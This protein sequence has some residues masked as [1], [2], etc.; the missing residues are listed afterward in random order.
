MSNIFTMNRRQFLKTGATFLGAGLLQPVLPLIGAGKDVSAAYPDEI[1]SIEK[2][3]HGKVKPGDIISKDNADLVKDF[4]PEGLYA[5]LL[6]GREIKI[7]EASLKPQALVPVPW[8]DATLK[9]QDQ[10]ILDAKGQLWTKGGQPWIGGYPFPKAKTALEAMWNHFFN[11]FGLDDSFTITKEVIVDHGGSVLRN[12]D[13]VS[14]NIQPVG[15]VAVDPIPVDENFKE[16][17][18]R[19]SVVILSPFDDFGTSVMNSVYYDGDKMPT[20]DGYIPTLKRVRKFPS[21][22]RFDPVGPYSVGTVSE[23]YIQGDPLLTWSWDLVAT[24]PLLGPSPANIGGR[25]N[26]QG[27]KPDEFVHAY[28]EAKYPRSTWELR[29]EILVIDGTCHIDGCPYTKKRVYYDAIY[30]RAQLA[31]IYDKAGKL[32]K[33][34]VFYF[35]DTG[36]KDKGGNPIPCRSGIVFADV[37]NDYHDNIFDFNELNGQKFSANTGLK[38]NDWLTPGALQRQ[39]LK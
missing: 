28:S 5:E 39:A 6:H 20:T 30:G 25:A 27:R 19:T 22:D 3:S 17:L 29:P 37:Q 23:Y 13:G 38:I 1:L 31:D 21:N 11:Y 34:I 24:K 16:Y 36:S 26:E 7:A 9:N 15:R 8:I 4:A 10:A 14:V 32:W 35:G 18:L 12:S 2:Y 33:F